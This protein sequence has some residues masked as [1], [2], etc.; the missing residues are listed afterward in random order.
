MPTGKST[1]EEEVKDPDKE[2][3][4]RTPKKRQAPRTPSD[5]QQV[6]KEEVLTVDRTQDIPKVVVEIKEKEEDV[7][8]TEKVKKE[9]GKEEDDE[10]VF[11]EDAEAKK[12]EDDEDLGRSHTFLVCNQ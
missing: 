11:L 12:H 5:V 9:E 2:S 1:A 6:D 8:E 7:V 4:E 3:L 10:P